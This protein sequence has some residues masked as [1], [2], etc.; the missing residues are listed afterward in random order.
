MATLGRRL[1]SFFIA[2]TVLTGSLLILVPKE[3]SGLSIMAVTPLDD[4]D[5]PPWGYYKGILPNPIEGGDLSLAYRN[6]S[7][8]T[9][10]VPVWGAPSPFY[11]LSTDLEGPWGEVNV[12]QLIRENGMFPLVNMNF[13][14]EG[15]TLVQHPSI[16]SSTLNSPEWRSLYLQSVK[17]VI[18]ASR[19]LYIS[20]GNEV[21]LWF[22]KYG[23]ASG[24]DNGFQ[25]YVSLYQE[26]YDKVK[27]ISP[28]TQVFC[29]F[30]RE[31]VSENREADMS[32]TEMF[33]PDRLDL[34]VLTSHPFSVTGIDRVSDIDDDYYSGVLDHTGPKP[35]GLSEISWTSHTDNG[36][37]EE[38]ANFIRNATSRLTID[39]GLDMEIIGWTRLHDP[40]PGEMTGL[41]DQEGTAKKALAAWTNN[42]GPSYDRDHRT[43]E[44]YEDFGSYDHDLGTIFF[45]MDP[46]DV[47]EYEIWNGT[48][49]SN[50][51]TTVKVN[52][53]IRERTLVLTS[54]E[55]ATGSMQLRIKVTD[56]MGDSNWTFI[57]VDLTGI[58]DAPALKGAID[59]LVFSEGGSPFYDLS[60]FIFDVDDALNT[61]HLEIIEAPGLIISVDLSISPYMVIYSDQDE[62]H[63]ET[64]IF[65]RVSDPHD[66]G[67][68]ILIPVRILPINDP[69]TIE[70][71][72]EI[73]FQ[74]DSVKEL[75]FSEWAMDQ[76]DTDL[77][78]NFTV[79]EDAQVFLEMENTTL[80]M[81]PALNWFGSFVLDVNVSDGEEFV[82]CGVPVIVTP[83][84]DAPI[85]NDPPSIYILEDEDHLFD[86]EDLSPYDP[87]GDMLYWY[88]ENASSLIR[89][90]AIYENNTIR[91]RPYLDGF[92]VGTFTLR[93][94]DGRGGVAHAEYIVYIEAVNDPPE[95]IAPDDWSLQVERGTCRMVDLRFVPYFVEDVDDPSISLMAVTDHPTATVN[96]LVINISVP[97]D[98]APGIIMM[99]VYITDPHGASS[100]AHNLTLEVIDPNGNMGDLDI[101]DIY[102]INEDGG[103]LITASGETGQVI[104]VV[105]TRLSEPIGS[106]RMIESHKDPGTYT[107]ELI[108]PGWGDGTEVSVHLSRSRDGPNE[109]GELPTVFIYSTGDKDRSEDGDQIY[110]Y[111]IGITSLLLLVI[112]IGAVMFIRSRTKMV[113]EPDDG[114]VLEE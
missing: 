77:L 80:R 19:P 49:Y 92:G 105:F 44:L 16:P 45:D 97:L 110:P 58:N 71:P 76:D 4:P 41:M 103:V 42:T 90:V 10:F 39:Q 94:Q 7:R 114:P 113:S 59:E 112:L 61:L 96:G 62:F 22:E 86:L 37:E 30:A 36:G 85:I 5:L 88:L 82:S 38:Q 51:T 75:D 1:A 27:A 15:L 54:V 34:V 104:W 70:A 55:N 64:H 57:L 89:S 47:L 99:K 60:Y 31:V 91:I 69:P 17:D 95:F 40:A 111:I 72:A 74:E 23:N 68:D 106:Y 83:V 100:T 24:D 33:D 48:A 101:D 66:A 50:T 20:L 65:M 43:I 46:W 28:A 13:Y 63:G 84:N 32:V 73:T 81:T 25:Y 3:T 26:A 6:A 98:A 9:Q 14:E 21:N 8:F 2:I 108:D 53:L 11:N 78:W 56:W 79:S 67:C 109:S 87:D 107:L 93:V 102:I 12:D 35:F 52:A 18:N 29:T